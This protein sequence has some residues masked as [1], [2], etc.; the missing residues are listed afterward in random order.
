M[1]S[2]CDAASVCD[3][4]MT[5]PKF[6]GLPLTKTRQ[7][8]HRVGLASIDMGEALAY[9]TAYERLAKLQEAEGT[10]DLAPLFPDTA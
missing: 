4:K 3:S 10:S 1:N 9:L 5:K 6:D 8:A 7:Q 2:L